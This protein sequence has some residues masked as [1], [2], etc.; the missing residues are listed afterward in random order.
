MTTNQLLKGYH[1][2]FSGLWA[3]SCPHCNN[4]DNGF[5][6][7]AIISRLIRYTDGET[8]TVKEIPIKLF[9]CGI[10]ARHFR[11]LPDFIRKFKRYVSDDIEKIAAKYLSK[12]KT[13]LQ[14]EAEFNGSPRVH[15]G[16]REDKISSLSKTTIWAWVSIWAAMFISMRVHKATT[17]IPWIITDNYFIERQNSLG[18]KYKSGQRRTELIRAIE[19]LMNL[20][21]EFVTDFERSLEM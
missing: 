5:R 11:L 9:F 8:V 21:S 18:G 2:N 16:H 14:K 20:K 10:C 1:S 6:L 15:S 19:V 4:R 3:K 17:G 13:S 12:H 7:R